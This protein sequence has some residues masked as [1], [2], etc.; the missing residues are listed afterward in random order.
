MRRMRNGPHKSESADLFCGK[1][2]IKDGFRLALSRSW[3]HG[4]SWFHDGVSK[5]P[6][7]GQGALGFNSS[8]PWLEMVRDHTEEW[9]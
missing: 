4:I 5:F 7:L 9:V 1:G 3:I 6:P 2:A 8:M